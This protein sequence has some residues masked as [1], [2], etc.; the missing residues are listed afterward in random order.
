MNLHVAAAIKGVVMMTE[1][2]SKNF[3]SFLSQ[4]QQLDK[5][6]GKREKFTENKSLP[7]DYKQNICGEGKGK[8]TV[9]LVETKRARGKKY[10][11]TEI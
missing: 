8:I 4:H 5:K 3:L 1:G 11:F 2:D 9:A 7:F 10:L 6:K